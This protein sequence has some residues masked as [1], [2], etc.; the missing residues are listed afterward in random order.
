MQAHGF[1]FYFTPLPGVLP[2]FP[3]RYWYAIGLRQ[4]L[5]LRDGPRGFGQDSTC[6]AL[7]RCRIGLPRL[8][9]TGVSPSA[10]S[11][12]RKFRFVRQSIS[13]VLQPRT[14]REHSGLGSSLFDRHYWGNRLF[15]SPPPGT[16]MFQ[17]PGF[18]P[19]RAG[20]RP[21]AVRVAPFGHVRINSRLQIPGH[22]RSLPRP[23]SPAE[24]KASSVRSDFSSS[25]NLSLL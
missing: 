21:S 19:A 17:F 6:P 8:A 3:S 25:V 9:R 18:A 4:S 12:S 22:F 20:A 7:L 16:K 13:P 11:L 23:S 24:A 14:V 1:R 5:A 15:L 10:P 2:T